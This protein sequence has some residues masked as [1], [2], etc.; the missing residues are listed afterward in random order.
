MSF[1]KKVEFLQCLF[2][3]Q[4]VEGT[5]WCAPKLT[6][7]SIEILEVHEV[8]EFS[9]AIKLVTEAL[10]RYFGKEAEGFTI[11]IQEG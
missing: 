8:F 10:Q 5:S 4:Y 11:A 2:I 3:T 6:C 9:L 7:R 1:S